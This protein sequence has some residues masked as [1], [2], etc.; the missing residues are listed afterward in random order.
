M[1]RFFVLVVMAVALLSS[2]QTKQAAVKDLRVFSQELQL[3]SSYYSYNDWE[4]AGKEYYDINKKISKHAGEYSDMELKEISELNGRCVRSFTNGA[5]E[6]VT[7][8][9]DMLKAFISGLLK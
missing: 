4:K 9:V 1:K 3:R 5:V 2:C 6:K 7:G 8:A